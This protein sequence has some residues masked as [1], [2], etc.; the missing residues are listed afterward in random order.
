[1]TKKKTQEAW[2]LLKCRNECG[3]GWREKLMC[4]EVNRHSAN[5]CLLSKPAVLQEWR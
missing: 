2:V 5:F 3:A 1:M 4:E